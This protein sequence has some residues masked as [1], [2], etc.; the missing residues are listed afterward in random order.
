MDILEEMAKF[1]RTNAKNVL[2]MLSTLEQAYIGDYVQ[3]LE[4]AAEAFRGNAAANVSPELAAALIRPLLKTMCK[5]VINRGDTG[6]DAS[7]LFEWY[8]YFVDNAQY[9]Q[10]RAITYGTPAAGTNTGNGQILRLTKDAFNYDIEAVHIESKRFLCV[11]DY[12]TGTNRGAEV[13]VATGQTA[14][15]DDLERSGSSAQA[16]IVGATADDSLLSNASFGNFSNTAAAPT[17]IT[18]WTSVTPTTVDSTTYTFD[19][20]NYFR[21]APSESTPY[22]LNIK[23][24]CLLRQKLSLNGTKLQDGV[25]YILAV[26]WNRAVGSGSG[27]LTLRMGTASTSVSVSAQTGWTITTVPTSPGQSCWYRQFAQDDLAIEIQWARSSGNLLIDDVMLLPGQPFEGCFYWAIPSSTSAWTPWRVRDSFTFAD[28][29]TDSKIQKWFWR[30]F[31][32]Y[33]PH[34]LGSSISPADP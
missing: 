8:K 11:A 29:A 21:A 16:T 3:D 31:N 23:A 28:Q 33:L 6:S 24:S 19:G 15:K 13:F 2:T 14:A 32:A 10:S 34:S 30:A 1:G 22:A 17:D 12:Q 4:N 18:D 5:S 25:P 27:T 9:V 7:M 26:A 20:T